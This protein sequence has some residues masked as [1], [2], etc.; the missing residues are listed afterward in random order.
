MEKTLNGENKC[1]DVLHVAVIKA[2]TS[3]CKN[4]QSLGRL[5]EIKSFIPI[6]NLIF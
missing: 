2:L 5:T 6:K 4:S 3:S 1:T